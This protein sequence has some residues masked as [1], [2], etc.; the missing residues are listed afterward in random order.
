MAT[1]AKPVS[2][3]AFGDDEES[4]AANQEYKD[5]MA[6]LRQ[7][8]NERSEKPFFDPTWLAAAQGFAT[9]TNTGSFF[10]SLG[11]VAGNIGKAQES[12]QKKAQ[13]L[14]NMRLELAG[15]DV[16]RVN[17]QKIMRGLAETAGMGKP[18]APAE[19]TAQTAEQV[20]APEGYEVVGRFPPNPNAL[21]KQQ[22]FQQALKAGET[23]AAAI[24]KS[25]LDYD[26][27]V[28]GIKAEGGNVIDPRT[29]TIYGK[30][31]TEAVPVQFS[32]G[33]T[34]SLP[35]MEARQYQGLLTKLRNARPEEQ[36][37]IANQLR[38]IQ[39]FYSKGSQAAI[40]APPAAPVAPPV[41]QVAQQ[42]N[43]APAIAPRPPPTVTPRP[44]PPPPPAAAPAPTAQTAPV[45]APPVDTSKEGIAAAQAKA[46]QKLAVEQA[47]LTEQAKAEVAEEAKRKE[48]NQQDLRVTIPE[49]KKAAL[50]RMSLGEQ[51]AKIVTEY[52][53]AVGVASNPGFLSA[54][55]KLLEGGATVGGEQAKVSALE[56]AYATLK[57]TPQELAARRQMVSLAAEYVFSQR[58]LL[59]GQGAISDFETKTLEKLGPSIQDDATTARFKAEIMQM[60]GKAQL[61]RAELFRKMQKENP[62]LGWRDFLGSEANDEF[63]AKYNEKISKA[64]DGFLK[65]KSNKAPTKS[66]NPAMDFANSLLKAKP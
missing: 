43:A 10:E 41:Q 61:E 34:Y 4:N 42:P 21:T 53:K 59:K 8:Y 65:K 45:P 14:A 18:A 56:E 12:E 50:D 17:Q 9:P 52:P 5:A 2:A 25:W 28:H 16:N 37:G 24:N 63:A 36:A 11:N 22:F 48:E 62:S 19:G 40:N 46:A 20:A 58:A 32:D 13:E 66:S 26:Q 31:P 49:I 35:P 55:I 64:Y 7:T 15:M 6:K 30:I 38:G 54:A 51:F 60:N 23:N 29:G 39:D 33:K 3:F 47:R 27:K 44:P 1:S 57:G